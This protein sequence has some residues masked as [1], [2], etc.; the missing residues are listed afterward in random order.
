MIILIFEEIVTKKIQC[1][2]FVLHNKKNRLIDEAAR[3]G[4]LF[5]RILTVNGI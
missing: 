1:R 2:A 4:T 5:Y 3:A